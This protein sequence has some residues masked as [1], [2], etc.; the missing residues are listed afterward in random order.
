[1]LERAT[2]KTWNVRANPAD[3]R[4]AERQYN[5]VGQSVRRQDHVV[6]DVTMPAGAAGHVLPPAAVRR[7]RPDVDTIEIRRAPHHTAHVVTVVATRRPA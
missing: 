2:I 3:R 7:R 6:D 5:D 4:H 1:M